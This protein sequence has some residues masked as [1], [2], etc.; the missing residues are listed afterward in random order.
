MENSDYTKKIK[1]FLKHNFGKPE[2]MT[3]GWALMVMF[4]LLAL[5]YAS[6]CALKSIELP[7]A[8]TSIVGYSSLMLIITALVY[9]FPALMLS[10][11]FQLKVPGKYTGVGVLLL[12]LLSGIPLMMIN[13]ALYNL[14]A[15]L[16]LVLNDKSIYPVFFSFG[17]GSE[18]TT[19]ALKLFSQTVIPAFGAAIFFFGLLWSR[20][21]STERTAA[22]VVISL[23]FALSS[24][25]FTSVLG[26]IVVGIWCCFLRSRAHNIWAPFVCLIS[27]K[28]SEYLFPG[29][30]AKI[31]IFN[32]Q[33]YAD[34]D[35]TFFYS[36]LTA[37]FMGYL[38]L[39]F[40]I[41]VL[42]N[43]E[44]YVKHEFDDETENATIPPFDKSIRLSLVLALGI[45]ITLWVL[46][47]KGVHL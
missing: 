9:V 35:S 33:T 1:N 25:D 43:F 11:D 4:A 36:S 32:V 27:L 40:F 13:V 5:V 30:L 45:I 42:N 2:Q 44:N 10:Q 28:V 17:G 6:I 15:W 19:I 29:I 39:Q 16:T 7:I 21:K 14:S 12:S 8:V 31:D 46:T 41:R 22:I 26:L 47:I 37:C 24:L 23:S 20:F 3:W 18:L 34:I 38:L